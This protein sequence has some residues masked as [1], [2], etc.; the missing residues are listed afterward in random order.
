MNLKLTFIAFASIFI[1]SCSSSGLG[2]RTYY[3][4]YVN[5]YTP[6]IVEQEW[7]FRGDLAEVRVINIVRNTDTGITEFELKEREIKELNYFHYTYKDEVLEIPE[8][9][10]ILPLKKEYGGILVG[11][12]GEIFYPT[13]IRN[14]D[15]KE[16]K[17]RV[18]KAV[19]AAKNR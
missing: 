3:L 10:I 2:G 14:I 1:Y 19:Y 9:K 12:N 6:D 7:K 4:L 15:E 18:E 16:Q 17:E 5:G 13:P 8:I 11:K